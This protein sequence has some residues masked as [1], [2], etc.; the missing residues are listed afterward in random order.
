MKQHFST[1][2]YRRIIVFNNVLKITPFAV[3]LLYKMFFL[4]ALLV[5]FLAFLISF[6][7]KRSKTSVIVPTPFGKKPPEFIVGF[8]KTFWVFFLIYGLTIV[9]V[10]KDNF[11]LGVFALV[12]I[13]FVCSSYY[14]KPDSSFYIWVHAMSSKEFLKH[15]IFI[16]FRY[17]LLLS[18]PVFLILS[19]FYIDQIHITL[20]FVGMGWLYLMMYILVRYAFQNQGLEMLQGVIG[21]LCLLFPPIMIIAI[22]YFYNK[23]KNNL[24]LLLK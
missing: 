5:W 3:F 10:F 6:I 16:A 12:S 2:S 11:N 17:S 9:A 21:V 13:F 1:A 24:D 19:F 20:F 4:E 18:F 14:M 22:P 23:A 8:R 15:K 7:K